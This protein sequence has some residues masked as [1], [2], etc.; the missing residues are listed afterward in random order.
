MTLEGSIGRLAVQCCFLVLAASMILGCGG[1]GRRLRP[2][3]TFSYNLIAVPTDW[4]DERFD[5]DKDARKAAYQQAVY[6]EYGAPDFFRVLY[7]R[8]GRVMTQREMQAKAWIERDK[9]RSNEVPEFEWIYLEPKLTFRFDNR[10]PVKGTLPDNIRIMTEY[11]DPQE[12]KTT[13]DANRNQLLIYQ[14]YDRG[15]VFYFLDGALQRE[16]DQTAM[17]GMMMRR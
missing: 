5:W 14:Y 8:T 12:I 6:E 13:V 7:D 11:G 16:E 15:K 2:D 3:P 10:G 9:R 4:P 1:K 17:P